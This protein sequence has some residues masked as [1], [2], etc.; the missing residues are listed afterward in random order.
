MQW[1]AAR[2]VGAAGG[3]VGVGGVGGLAG[4]AVGAVWRAR[5][6]ASAAGTVASAEGDARWG[7]RSCIAVGVLHAGG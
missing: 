2:V 3:A 7:T 4:N 5:V 6:G 1:K